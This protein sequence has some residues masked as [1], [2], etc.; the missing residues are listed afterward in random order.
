MWKPISAIS[1]ME[2]LPEITAN[3]NSH[4]RKERKITFTLSPDVCEKM[5]QSK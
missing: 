3:E 1:N 5:Q 4:V 2:M